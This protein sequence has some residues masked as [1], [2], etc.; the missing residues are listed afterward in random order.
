M[1]D[2]ERRELLRRALDGDVDAALRFAAAHADAPSAPAA[3]EDCWVVLVVPRGLTFTMDR[4]HVISDDV[5]CMLKLDEESALESA[6]QFLMG[7][8]ELEAKNAISTRYDVARNRIEILDRMSPCEAYAWWEKNGHSMG[9]IGA[10]KVMRLSG[11]DG[12]PTAV[13]EQAVD[14]A[15]AEA[16]AW[17]KRFEDATPEVGFGRSLEGLLDEVLRGAGQGTGIL[18]RQRIIEAAK[19]RLDGR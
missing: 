6:K 3:G 17:R 4:R 16:L 5:L 14:A 2:E 15:L 10:V 18:R 8:F 13:G 19:K 12:L 11:M 9:Y 7:M 1:K